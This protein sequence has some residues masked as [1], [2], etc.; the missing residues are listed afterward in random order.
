VLGLLDGAPRMP[1][2]AEWLFAVFGRVLS[3]AKSLKI[4]I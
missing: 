2:G 1:G 4:S 3:P